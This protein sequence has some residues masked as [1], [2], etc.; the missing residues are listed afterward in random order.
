MNKE[1]HFTIEDAELYGIEKAILLYNIRFWLDKNKAN[2]TNIYV[3]PVDGKEY[4]WTFNSGTAFGKI[5]SYMKIK[6]ITKWL[7]EMER[8]S[9]VI[10][11]KFNKKGYDR[12]KWYTTLEY[13]CIAPTEQ[14]TAPLERPIPDSKQQIVNTDI[15][16]VEDKSSEPIN[17]LVCLPDSFGKTPIARLMTAY[18]GLWLAKFGIERVARDF[19]RFGK[20]MKGLLESFTEIQITILMDTYFDW[21]GVS[22]DSQ[23]DND[24]LAGNGFSVEIM[25]KRVDI[26]IA[27][28]KNVLGGS[29]GS[30]EGD[31][32]FVGKLLKAKKII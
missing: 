8:D 25:S 23:K 24:F 9:I 31:R 1:H 4:Y 7:L 30:V 28:V 3:N 20:A 13:Q 22:G 2:G 29:W 17:P 6:S 11:A 5:F 21:M 10:S 19:P 32:A 15:P 27:Y 14:S 16:M 18:N 12:T 26:L